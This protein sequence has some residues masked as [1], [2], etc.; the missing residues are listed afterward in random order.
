MDT[1]NRSSGAGSLVVTLIV[2]LVVGFVI[3]KVLAP[4]APSPAPPTKGFV[5]QPCP[6][7]TAT[8]I[9][10][11]SSGQPQPSC[12]QTGVKYGE[13]VSWATTPGYYPWVRFN[14]LVAT[15]VL[16]SDQPSSSWNPL[17][18]YTPGATFDYQLNVLPTKVAP[19]TAMTPTP[20]LYGRIIIN[21]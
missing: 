8:T 3:A 14:N 10:L 12:V 11:D 20:Q 19:P 15:P 16:S 9:V 1:P 6:S 5:A 18:T 21:K 13:T 2:G 7:G 17:P 4:V